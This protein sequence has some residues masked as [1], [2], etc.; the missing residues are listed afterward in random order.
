MTEVLATPPPPP[1]PPPARSSN[2]IDFVRPFA[3]A[4]EDPR[5]LPKFLLGGLFVLLSFMIIGL[6]FIFGYLARLTR[7]VIAGQQ[8]PLP[9]WDDLGE[10]FVEG[11][12]LFAVG[13]VYV[14]PIFA[15]I[16]FFIVPVIVA[17]QLDIGEMTHKLSEAVAAG[18]WCL[19]MPISLALSVWL[20]GALLMS[21][22]DQNFGAGFD[23]GR[24]GGFIRANAA[25]Y[26]L[27]FVIWL[28]ARF[29]ASLGFL[30]F[31]VGIVFTIYWSYVVGTYAFAE[32]YRLSNKP[33]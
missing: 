1:P 23:F 6:F 24:I 22:V 17:Q 2:T 3:F 16:G 33:R 18:A 13:F 9:E 31:C 29:A 15:L 25:N 19:I 7:N 8:H 12:R 21:A 20:P 28:I 26:I 30:L 11:F 27:A 5:W 32:A 4:F 14:L 10:Y